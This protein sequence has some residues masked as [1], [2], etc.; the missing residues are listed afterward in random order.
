MTDWR[1]IP[2][3]GTKGTSLHAAC[4]RADTEAIRLSLLHTKNPNALTEDGQSPLWILA[5][6]SAPLNCWQ[7]LLPFC[8]PTIQWHGQTLLQYLCAMKQPDDI[9]LFLLNDN[10]LRP[11]MAGKPL[12]THS[13]LLDIGIKP[14]ATSTSL[15]NVGPLDICLRNL[16]ARLARALLTQGQTCTFRQHALAIP[17]RL[18]LVEGTTRWQDFIDSVEVFLQ[19]MAPDDVNVQGSDGNNI[20]NLCALFGKSVTHECPIRIESLIRTLEKYGVNLDAPAVDGMTPLMQSINRGHVAFAEAL[21]RHNVALN[22]VDRL[23][24][25]AVFFAQHRSLLKI[26]NS[27]GISVESRSFQG[28]T[29]LLDAIVEGRSID[30]LLEAGAN[31]EVYDTQR[32]S[33]L[34]YAVATGRV[35]VLKRLLKC[36]LD[37]NIRD[38]HGRT[39]LHWLGHSVLELNDENTCT[40]CRQSFCKHD[41]EQSLAILYTLLAHEGNLCARD[42]QG[43][44]PFFL[45]KLSHLPKINP[46]PC[47][48]NPVDFELSLIFHMVSAAAL[49]G[50]GR[51][52]TATLW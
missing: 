8:D 33:V 25:S 15:C 46:F 24:R 18:P 50:M 22:T 21:I 9:V 13:R 6:T 35:D 1:T 12:D 47:C 49:V 20:V 52:H 45:P 36:N 30:V 41:F 3:L 7:I 44:L 28:R 14:S 51:K 38:G 17:L 34:H 37:A 26:L 39:P 40:H 42:D 27:Q 48:R 31:I 23:G 5:R 29:P 16:N 32:R 10:R 19:S 4:S 2:N 43:N 11:L